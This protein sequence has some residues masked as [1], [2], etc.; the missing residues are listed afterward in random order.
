FRPVLLSVAVPIAI[1]LAVFAASR[2]FRDFV[3]SLDIRVATTLQAWRI[4]GFAFLMLYAH[5][6]LPGLFAWPAGLGDVAMGLTAPFV[7]LALMRRPEFARSGR[8][9]V[10]NLLGLFDFVVAAV[11]ST[12]VSAAFPALSAGPITSAPL[13]H[14]PLILFPSF[15]VPLFVFMHLSVLFQVRALRARAGGERRTNAPIGADVPGAGHGPLAVSLA[16]T[17]IAGG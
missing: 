13:E 11:T 12:L 15:I 16:S 4:I 5:G 10:W 7:V 14:W 8:F 1:F 3:L 6:V 2:G 17:R 9:I